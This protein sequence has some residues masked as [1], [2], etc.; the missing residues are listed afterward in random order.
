MQENPE[1]IIRAPRR[2]QNPNEGYE[3]YIQHG[4]QATTAQSRSMQKPNERRTPD[5]YGRS[6]HAR[7]Y[8]C[9]QLYIF[10]E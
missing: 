8:A 10:M 7:Q 5:T 9:F 1:N 3:Q 2:F 6:R 4:A